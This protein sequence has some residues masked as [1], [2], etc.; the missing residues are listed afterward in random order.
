MIGELGDETYVLCLQKALLVALGKITEEN[1]RREYFKYFF[2]QQVIKFL[3]TVGIII[4]QDPKSTS[5]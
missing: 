4:I 3:R 1:L 2:H 5:F